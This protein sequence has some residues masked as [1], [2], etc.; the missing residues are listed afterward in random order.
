MLKKILDHIKNIF[1]NYPKKHFYS[2]AIGLIFILI[3]GLLFNMDLD[4]EYKKQDLLTEISIEKLININ[5]TSNQ[6]NYTVTKEL[7]IRP[8]DSLFSVL[9]RFGIEE[10]NIL[11]IVNSKNSNLL[12]KIKIGKLIRVEIDEANEV[13]S[14]NYIENFNSGVKAKRQDNKYVIEKYILLVE[15]VK[16]FK[17]V[18]INSSLYVDGLKEGLPDSV[19]MDLVYIFGWDIDFVHDIRPED[20]YSLIYEEIYVNGEKKLDG[21]ILIAEFINRKKEYV[22]I[23]YKLEDGTSEYFSPQGVNVKKAFLRTPVKIFSYISSKYNLK[24]KH[25]V[26]HQIRAHTGVDY[27]ASRGTPVQA[28]GDG[29]VVYAAE[30]GGYGN[31]I[32]IKHTEDYSTRYA[33]LDRFHPKIKVGKRVKQSSTIGYVGRTGVATGDHLHYEFRV[34]GKHTNPLTVPLPN[35]RP[36]K[37]SEL[38]KYSVHSEEILLDLKKYQK[39]SL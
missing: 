33:H 3:L 1:I 10:K 4:P 31:L 5:E 22:A 20:T 19:I 13:I 12:A 2:L 8:N 14:L 27:A 28:T 38:Q 9:R 30:S 32:E 36:I 25:P 35:A 18:T 17:K 6:E 15:K 37:L 26:F 39:L 29:V 16:V 11:E 7:K 23:R 21:D 24:R 34:N